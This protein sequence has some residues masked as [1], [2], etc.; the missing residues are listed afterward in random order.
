LRRIAA[1]Q[2]VTGEPNTPGPAKRFRKTPDA[3]QIKAM[4]RLGL[5]F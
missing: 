1:E 2:A 5:R 3:A 4:L